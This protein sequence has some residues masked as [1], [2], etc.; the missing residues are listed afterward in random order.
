MTS[1]VVHWIRWYPTR[2]RPDFKRWNWKCY[3]LQCNS[4][5]NYF[6]SIHLSM[7]FC[8]HRHSYTKTKT[9]NFKWS[10]FQQFDCTRQIV[11]TKWIRFT[12]HRSQLQMSTQSVGQFYFL[13]SFQLLLK[14]QLDFAWNEQPQQKN[15][16]LFDIC[17]LAKGDT[18]RLHWSIHW[19]E[20][21]SL[22]GCV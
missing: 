2:I 9:H 20:M 14:R 17:G 5:K 10:V 7:A 12:L 22:C 6:F 15:N 16:S 1:A 8:F 18:N 19:N 3:L 4:M 11:I 21:R 13:S